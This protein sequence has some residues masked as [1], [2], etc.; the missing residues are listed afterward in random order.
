MNAFN[1]SRG[2][3]KA[4][5]EQPLETTAQGPSEDT[6]KLLPVDTGKTNKGSANTTAGKRSMLI[7]EIRTMA[8]EFE[9]CGRLKCCRQITIYEPVHCHDLLFSLEFTLQVTVLL[10][11]HII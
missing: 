6:T 8:A 5:L 4:K 11:A 9:F 3:P 10:L 1:I 7:G 2:K